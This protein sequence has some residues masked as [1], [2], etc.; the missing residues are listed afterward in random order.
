MG[1]RAGSLGGSDDGDGDDNGNVFG[2]LHTQRL[3][4]SRGHGEEVA[5]W[6]TVDGEEEE[7]EGSRGVKQRGEAEV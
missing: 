7:E 4:A 6:V 1:S 5:V 3:M 2:K